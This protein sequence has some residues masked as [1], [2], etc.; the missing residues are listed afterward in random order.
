[1]E[2]TK[3][4]EVLLPLPLAGTF[5]YRVPRILNQLIVTGIRVMVQFGKKKLYSGLV[6]SEHNQ[7][8]ISYEAKYILSVLDVQPTVN[9]IQIKFWQWMASYYSCNF[10]DV[11]KAALPGGLLVSSET[12]LHLHPEFDQAEE[13]LTDNEYVVSEALEI[14]KQLSLDEVVKILNTDNIHHLINK[15]IAK[16][17][18][19]VDEEL[20]QRYKP[21]KAVYLELTDAFNSDE[22]IKAFFDDLVRAPKQLKVA[23]IFLSLSGYFLKELKPVKSKELQ[24]KSDSASSIILEL[25]K[26]GFLLKL[27]LEE[28]RLDFNKLKIRQPYDLSDSQ[29]KAYN[30]IN[31][32]FEQDKVSLLHGVTSSGKTEIYVKLI[33][34][35][36]KQNKQV[37]FLLPEIAITTQ[38]IIRLKEY[39]GEAVAVYHSKFNQN[40]RVEVWKEMLKNENSRFKIFIGARS[41]LFL[42]FH[43]LGLVIVDE[44]HESTFKQFEPAPRYHARDSAI[45]LAGLFKA[46]VLLGSATPSLESYDNAIQNKYGLVKLTERFGK[47]QLPEVW[48]ADLKKE[49]QQGMKGIFSN[50]LINEIRKSLANN[51]QV[52]LFKNRR[53]FSPFLQCHTCGWMAPCTR[54]D[55]TLTYHKYSNQLKCHY[56][57]YQINPVKKC[58]ACNSVQVRTVGFGTERIEEELQLLLPNA[59][60]KRMDLDTT[61]SKNAYHDI[62][63]Q[64]D[65]AKIDILIGTQMVAKGLDFKNVSL[66]GVLDADGMLA[67]PDFRAHEKAFQLM[68]Q[69]AGRAGRKSKRGKV[70][71]QTSNPY[72]FINLRVIDGN[73]TEFAKEMMRERKEFFYPP[74]SRLVKITIKHKYPDK[75]EELSDAL[76]VKLKEAFGNRVL[77]PESPPV[78]RV[79]NMYL[80]SILIKL[81]KEKSLLK[82]KQVI[83]EIKENLIAKYKFPIFGV[84]TDVDP[85]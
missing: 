58:G 16:K 25:V 40:E 22:K 52:I 66:V 37:L 85:Y 74:I 8:P 63:S 55:I 70:V 59:N 60:L 39:F 68:T 65:N 71:I 5:T 6:I 61:K 38:L 11:Y 15:L 9:H 47:V 78:S 14:N 21:K 80:K 29:A 1:M 43:R 83:H 10:G 69:V 62:I 79:R 72:H 84:I 24:L 50:L 67:Y 35:C 12:I 75:L 33:T 56:C 4:I 19:I 53:G 57:G 49:R 51:E 48:I 54:C 18:V 20:K 3:F 44:E 82:Q 42:P 45:V 64:F 28:S 73:Y 34:N 17:V 76:G 81:N 46:N 31:Q 13:E 32:F 36:L 2:S 27:E 26:R 7:A 41:S 77:G 30:E 23:Q